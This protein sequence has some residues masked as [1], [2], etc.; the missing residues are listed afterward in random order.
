MKT[1]IKRMLFL[2]VLTLSGAMLAQAQSAQ[3]IEMPAGKTSVSVK[4]VG[5]K[6]Y[7]V[8]IAANTDCKITL[9]SRGNK[10]AFEILDAAGS[11]MTEGS[12]GRS[13]E[14]SFAEAGEYTIKVTGTA[15]LAHTLTIKLTPANQ[16]A[17]K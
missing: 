5:T 9:L 14:G 8:T 16:E 1:T 15:K 10:A 7:T 13:F 12:D 17:R 6:T 4:G 3:K 2:V 11:D